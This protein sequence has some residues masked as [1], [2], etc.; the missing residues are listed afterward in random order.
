VHNAVTSKKI[1]YSVVSSKLSIGHR[2]ATTPTDALQIRN[3]AVLSPLT[4]GVGGGQEARVFG[5]EE[6]AFGG[7]GRQV[8]GA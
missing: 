4:T 5:G 6:R 8:A 3:T 2:E 1:F 7:R